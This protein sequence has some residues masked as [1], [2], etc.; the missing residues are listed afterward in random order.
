MKRQEYVSLR[1]WA[2]LML[3]ILAAIG[4]SGSVGAQPQI[5]PPVCPPRPPGPA[6]LVVVNVAHCST[7]NPLEG[8]K[9]TLRSRQA[10]ANANPQERTQIEGLTNAAGQF[11][12]WI[13]LAGAN[14]QTALNDLDVQIEKAGFAVKNIVSSVMSFS[15]PPF[16]TIAYIQVGACMEETGPTPPGPTPPGPTPPPPTPP[17]PPSPPGQAGGFTVCPQG[18][19][20]CPFANVAEAVR[21][22]Q[23]G[24]RIV[25][26]PGTYALSESLLID[27]SLALIGGG[28]R[29]EEVVL[30]G[31]GQAPA[32]V[33]RETEKVTVENLTVREGHGGTEE[34]PS[35]GGIHIEQ[36][37]EIVIKNVIVTENRRAGLLA[38]TVKDL[39]L[40]GVQA[41]RN[42]AT[43]RGRGQ[44]G[45][46]I[47]AT[48]GKIT[49]ATVRDNDA[50]GIWIRDF[51]GEP[52]DIVLSQS[53]IES[54]VDLGILVDDR[55]KAQLS[56]N[57][58]LNT[59]DLRFPSY[60]VELH[61]RAQVTLEK[62]TI[63]GNGLG[64]V[65]VSDVRAIL[66]ENTITRN[67]EW[68]VIMGFQ[69]VPN[70]TMQAEFIGN[71]ISGHRRCGLYIDFDEGIQVRGSGNRLI[72]NQGGNICGATQKVPPGF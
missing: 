7:Q 35:G 15:V 54:N 60:G 29:P 14:L 37:S 44:A 50:N 55:S 46:L 16:L 30:Q 22:A 8:A 13:F 63:Q 11:A 39:Q 17:T 1:N 53:V 69:E 68:G 2:M 67:R 24:D 72:N 27:R 71:E 36:A 26:A 21:A 70:E 12:A 5:C 19:P 6:T 10:G 28:S 57:Q 56:N 9:V 59:R 61:A 52:S 43:E 64:L 42:V 49:G 4:L 31:N 33:I 51:E 41:L 25:I 48:T 20:T 3:L 18:P 40:E 32:L 58:I 38:R 34:I 47:Y 45:L 62:N 66:R 23:T 65:M